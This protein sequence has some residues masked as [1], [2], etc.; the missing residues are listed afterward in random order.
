MGGKLSRCVYLCLFQQAQNP[1]RR[2][3]S[4]K[5]ISRDTNGNDTAGSNYVVFPLNMSPSRGA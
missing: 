5:T 3:N 1:Y 2:L 4:P